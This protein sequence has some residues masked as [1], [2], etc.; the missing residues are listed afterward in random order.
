MTQSPDTPSDRQIRAALSDR[1]DP[2]ASLDSR[3]EYGDGDQKNGLAQL[4]LALVNLIHELLEKQAI[5]RMEADTLSPEQL[6]RLGTVLMRQAREIDRL[7]EEFNL[8]PDD[9]ELDL[10]GVQYME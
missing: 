5:R 1:V 9:L 7:R 6:E 8:D 3:V 2:D 10:G 4:V